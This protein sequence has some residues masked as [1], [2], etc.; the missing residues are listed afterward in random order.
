[1]LPP[2]EY[3]HARPD[4]FG[5]LWIWRADYGDDFRLCYHS[6]DSVL[7]IELLVI[8]HI[9]L[10]SVLTRYNLTHSGL[11]SERTANR[12]V[13]WIPWLLFWL[14]Y[15]GETIGELLS[16]G[17][18]FL[19]STIAFYLAVVSVDICAQKSIS[20]TTRPIQGDSHT[21]IFC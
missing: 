7:W 19:T 13:V 9:P 16:W 11:C 20:F 14:F 3:Q 18:A 2:R 10:F 17:G 21:N 1:M 6:K 4:G 15:Q 12:L 8:G 5:S